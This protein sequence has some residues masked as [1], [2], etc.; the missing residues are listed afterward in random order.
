MSK[1]VEVLRVVVR[2]SMTTGLMQDFINRL[3]V[4]T[5]DI[6]SSKM[7]SGTFSRDE[8][9][10]HVTN[11]RQGSPKAQDLHDWQN[12]SPGSREMGI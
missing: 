6:I 7:A 10:T 11:F 8:V 5:K 9:L 4:C 12:I 2:E 1:T 3:I